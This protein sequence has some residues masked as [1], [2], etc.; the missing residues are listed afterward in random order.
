[1]QINVSPQPC[2][3]HQYVSDLTCVMS[4]REPLSLHVLAMSCASA[5][6]AS[7]SAD[8]RQSPLSLPLRSSGSGGRKMKK[9][10][11][12]EHTTIEDLLRSHD[13]CRFLLENKKRLCRMA[14]SPGSIYCG[15]HRDSSSLERVPC[16]LDPTHTVYRDKL[17]KHLLVC[18]TVKFEENLLQNC[19]YCLNC[20]SGVS[21]D[22]ASLPLD[23]KSIDADAL[24][25]KINACY[26]RIITDADGYDYV[27]GLHAP[28]Y[29]SA[30]DRA[31]YCR[32][33]QML[34]P[35]L[36]GS[37]VSEKSLRHARQ[38]AHIV[39]TMAQNDLLTS[40]E[41]SSLRLSYVELGSGQG[42]LSHAISCYDSSSSIVMVERAPNKHKVDKDLRRKHVAF[43]RLRMDIRHCNIA[44]LPSVQQFSSSKGPVARVDDGGLCDVV[45]VAKH[46]CGL[47]SDLAIRAATNAESATTIRGL[48]VAT[49]C[50]HALSWGDYTGRDFLVESNFNE[51][52]FLLLK[53]W[54]GWH[55]AKRLTNDA[56]VEGD[57][58]GADDEHPVAYS[59]KTIRPTSISVEEMS[60]VGKRIKRIFDHGRINFLRSRGFQAHQKQYCD[61]SLSPECFII[62]AKKK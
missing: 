25:R 6:L 57:C 8:P 1:M 46:L 58:D 9:L 43:Y 7:P 45:I 48:A 13:M 12:N 39:H 44:K 38:D 41:S 26:L 4:M 49:C 10:R 16:P 55:T 34:M 24:L 11:L 30:S 61:P 36:S 37:K 31:E 14:P 60:V 17:D 3:V 20:N 35:S 32:I 56:A 28:V 29:S 54:A 33:E 59:T 47:A 51:N 40:G 27:E 18:N 23:E 53:H 42:L 22:R 21:T 62:V 19:Y 2:R 5:A 50:H 15:N 52:E